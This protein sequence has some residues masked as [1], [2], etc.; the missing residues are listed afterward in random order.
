M[1]TIRVTVMDESIE[2]HDFE[3]SVS[4]PFLERVADDREYHDGLVYTIACG[5]LYRAGL[6]PGSLHNPVITVDGREIEIGEII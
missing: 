4:V 6:I 1:S 2:R 5:L 3:E